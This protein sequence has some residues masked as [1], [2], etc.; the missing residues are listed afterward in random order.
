MQVMEM[1]EEIYSQ[2]G[3]KLVYYR[4]RQGKSQEQLSE[5]CSLSR[6]RISLIE[7]GK[8]HFNMDTLILLTSALNVNLDEFFTGIGPIKKVD[9]R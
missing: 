2:I 8:C 4:R 6:S 3:K 1:Y 5:E 7:C 9:C